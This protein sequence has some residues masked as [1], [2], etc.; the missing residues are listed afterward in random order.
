MHFFSRYF[1]SIF[2][3]CG[4]LW[5]IYGKTWAKISLNIF[6]HHFY[7]AYISC[8][9]ITGIFIQITKA[10]ITNLENLNLENVSR[11]TLELKLE[12]LEFIK[13]YIDSYILQIESKL[14]LPF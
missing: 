6:V 5:V 7:T 8:I 12:E 3:G 13:A 1:Y 2:I 10:M 4:K 11:E 14:Y 9:E